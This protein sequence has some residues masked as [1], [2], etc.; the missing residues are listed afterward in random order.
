M[1]YL[2][3]ELDIHAIQYSYRGRTETE[4]AY[5]Y[6]DYKF[7]SVACREDLREYRMAGAE[8]SYSSCILPEKDKCNLK[9]VFNQLYATLGRFI[10]RWASDA[11]PSDFVTFCALGCEWEIEHEHGML[12]LRVYHTVREFDGECFRVE[13]TLDGLKQLER[14]FLAS[15]VIQQIVQL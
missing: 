10:E 6:N 8:G 15:T 11:D 13:P 1:A 4:T 9:G 5:T 14:E 3:K 2:H 12:R 7:P